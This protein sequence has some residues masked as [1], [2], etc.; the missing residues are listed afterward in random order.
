M[1]FIFA[2]PVLFLKIQVPFMS[3]TPYSKLM[4]MCIYT[5]NFEGMTT[6]NDNSASTLQTKGTWM[7]YM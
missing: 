5:Y 1:H 4:Y 2:F 7:M 6:D 3:S